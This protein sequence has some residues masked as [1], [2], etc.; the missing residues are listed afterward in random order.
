MRAGWL[1]G[2][3][4]WCG[5]T[6]PS[7]LMLIAFAA[8]APNLSGPV[9]VGLV[10]GLKLTAVAIVSQ[11]VW[12]MGRRL[13]PD[14]TRVAI[15]LGSIVLLSVLTTI[16]AQ[17]LVIALGAVL[18]T[19]ACRSDTA[20]TRPEPAHSIVSAIPVSRATS[21]AALV[22]FCVLL[23]GVPVAANAMHAAGSGALDQAL[24]LFDAFYRS[25]A[26]VF[27]GGHVVLPLLQHQRAIV[28]AVSAN[29]FLS[30]YGAAQAV[31]GPLF[32]FAAFLGWLM[33]A[34]PY[35]LAG[36]ALATAAIFLPGLLLVIAA[37]PHWQSLRARAST[38][39]LFA[40]VNAAVVGL[41]ATA[42]YSPVWTSAVRA[43]IDFAI[44]VIGFLLLVRWK[45]PP[46]A[47][48]T[49]CAVAGIAQVTFR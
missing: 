15:A 8:L 34:A 45:M 11:A 14:R 9:G 42:L 38:A 6:L 29:D 10:H 23:F 12:D 49:F 26:L 40:G 44:A 36:A 22:M 30:G 2:L 4:A 33:T 13:C 17:L 27:G 48:V 7:V 5:F 46:L 35:R 32:T 31:P 24:H 21:L 37:L 39:A 3:A 16:Y 41:L 25:G 18:G 20:Q 43:P 28:D 1:G 19:F 47:V